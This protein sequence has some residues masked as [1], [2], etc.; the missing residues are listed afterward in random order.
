MLEISRRLAFFPEFAARSAEIMHDAGFQRDG[1]ADAF[2]DHRVGGRLVDAPETAGGN[3]GG[4]GDVSAQLAV[5]QVAHDRAV[6]AARR[7]FDSW[8]TTSRDVKD[9]KAD[10][11][12]REP[13]QV[14]AFRDTWRD[15]IHSYLTYLRDRLA[16]ARE[17]LTPSGSV[18][19]Q[20]GD[21]NV[22]RVR[23]VMDEVFGSENFVS[24]IA[25][26]T[27]SGAGSP[28][29]QRSLP[30]TATYLIWYARDVNQMRYRQLYS[31][32]AGAKSTRSEYNWVELEDGS[33]RPMSTDERAG[34]LPLPSGARPLRF[35]NLTSQAVRTNSGV[36][37]VDIDGRSFRPGSVAVPPANIT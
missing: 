28:G 13:E 5:D 33:R 21:E 26:M 35:D 4:F 18:F 37:P 17:L 24:Q 16:L 1:G 32:K 14:K 20:I 30:A 23:A 6:A 19:V 7:A 3:T 2:V 31:D 29:D 15:G 22:H 36:Y 12:T 9:G 34:A 11:I 27:T 8:S 25:F 10:H